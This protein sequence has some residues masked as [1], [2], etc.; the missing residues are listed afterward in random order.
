MATRLTSPRSSRPTRR[1][2][3]EP[4]WL[5]ADEAATRLGISKPTLYAYVSRGRIHRE[6]DESG[7]RSRFDADEVAALANGRVRPP[8]PGNI[9]LRI[10]TAVTRI[11]E[12]SLAYR[13][14]PISELVGRS[15]F[16]AVAELLW[17]RPVTSW[18]ATPAGLRA[19][20]DCWSAAGGARPNP[21]ATASL[22]ARAVLAVGATDEYRADL[23]TDAVVSSVARLIGA[24]SASLPGVG[25][26]DR[27]VAARIWRR[28]LSCPGPYQR[29]LPGR[30]PPT[31]HAG[32][33]AQRKSPKASAPDHIALVDAALV[34]LA[35]HEL[36]T[37]T[38]A[39][40]LAASTR[41]DPY[42]AIATGLGVLSGPLHGSVS[43]DSFALLTD[44]HESGRPAGALA[45][46]LAS[47]GIVPGFGHKVYRG[48]D[49]RFSALMA[50]LDAA[51][52]DAAR[53]STVRALMAEAADRVPN[54]PN[55]DFAMA[56]LC[57]CCDLDPSAGEL[58]FAIARTAGWT[59][60]YLEELDEAPLRYRVR[61]VYR[62]A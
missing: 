15:G 25:P 38:F 48:P 54:A 35:D 29:S 20:A 39:V 11:D 32:S 59:A 14:R 5:S 10:G 28:S 44:A 7:R 57:F 21:G 9:E 36:A 16:E 34:A 61:A 55:I 53:R 17:Q 8:R 40:R 4:V 13:G 31:R 52:V 27:S 2:E 30:K 47:S 37:S 49:P 22:I 45:H 46:C 19:A 6:R 18:A 26:S 3:R 58:I 23:R 24:L 62:G 60:H 33:E 50:V 56:A 42:A 41:A 1:T 43:A 12:H 51:T